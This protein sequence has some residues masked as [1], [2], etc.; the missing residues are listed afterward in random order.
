MKLTIEDVEK[1][2]GQNAIDPYGRTLGK[3]VSVYSEVDGTVLAVEI[4]VSDLEYQ[5]ISVDRM[6]IEG[7]K[8]IVN[9][10]WRSEALKVISQVTRAKKRLKALEDLYGRGE[11]P[12]HAYVE[13]KRRVEEQIRRLKE[14]SKKVKEMINRRIYEL[15]DQVLKIEKALTALKM[16]YIAGE[17]GERSYK[18]AADMLRQ[19][20][21]RNLEEKKD[22]RSTLEKLITVVEEP[23]SIGIKEERAKAKEAPKAE[24]PAGEQPIVVQVLEGGT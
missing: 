8:V 5:T 18:V 12:N 20:R 6:T 21:D 16:S 23:V 7:G 4:K 19:S 13:F 11:I 2:V 3:I 15:E 17:I 24:T 10:T 14:E 22:A 9:P 1:Y